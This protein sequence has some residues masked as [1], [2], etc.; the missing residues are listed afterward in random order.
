MLRKL[1]SHC[2]SGLQL[3]SLDQSQFSGALVRIPTQDLTE[4]E[5]DWEIDPAGLVIMDKLGM[6]PA[7]SMQWHRGSDPANQAADLT[8]VATNACLLACTACNTIA[9]C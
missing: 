5:P 6:L 7:C 9:G 2:F 4:L 3:V 8:D 1:V